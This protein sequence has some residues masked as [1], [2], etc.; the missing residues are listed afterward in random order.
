MPTTRSQKAVEGKVKKE[1]KP[2]TIKQEVKNENVKSEP[3]DVK[4]EKPEV[5]H[6][7]KKPEKQIDENGEP[8]WMLGRNRRLVLSKFKG[9]EYVHVRIFYNDGESGNGR[10]INS[11]VSLHS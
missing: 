5:K 6:N 2:F 4:L 8:F 10:N 11:F 7:A 9:V 3:N 1:A